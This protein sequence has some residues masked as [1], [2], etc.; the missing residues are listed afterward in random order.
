MTALRQFDQATQNKL[1]KILARQT[2]RDRLARVREALRQIQE[3]LEAAIRQHRKSVSMGDFA[4]ERW[5]R[6]VKR[7]CFDLDIL[8]I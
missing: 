8:E 3:E 2:Q 4:E 1:D 7:V 5:L 6:E